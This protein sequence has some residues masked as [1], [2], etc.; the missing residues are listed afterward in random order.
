MA[1]VWTASLF[2]NSS[3]EESGSS[4][5]LRAARAHAWG[6]ECPLSH[7]SLTFPTWNPVKRIDMMCAAAAAASRTG[8]SFVSHE[9]RYA[10]LD[11]PGGGGIMAADAWTDG[12]C[13]LK[14]NQRSRKMR[15]LL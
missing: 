1:D 9:H 6:G 13:P 3:A 10:Q 5:V 8:I 14:C 7:P 11:V 12:R 4:K 2:A 15:P